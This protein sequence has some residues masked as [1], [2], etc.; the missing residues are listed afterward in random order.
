MT[1]FT[2]RA[3][4]ADCSTGLL[5][6]PTADM[7]DD[8]TFMITNNF[9]N[10][11][12]LPSSGWSYNSFQYGI[13][14]S[15]WGRME[16][17]YVCTLFNDYW[18]G[19]QTRKGVWMINQDRHF[20]G[21]IRL[22]KEGEFGLKWIPSLVVGASDPFTGG[23]LDYLTPGKVSGTGNGFFNRYFAVM[24]KHFQTH[25]GDLGVHAGYQYN[26]RKDYPINGPC[27]GINWSPVWLL[28]HG[29]LDGVN[30]IAEY[31]SRT[32]N[33]GFVASI[34]ENRFEAMFELQNF[35][36]INFG[37]RYKLRLKKINSL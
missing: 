15:F 14:V 19:R 30:L 33:M 8:G 24:T 37:L 20:T 10:K 35:N 18:K 25:W 1:V 21:R 29:I 22:L 32:V 16:V 36:S 2:C 9:L 27:F 6:M 31:D 7:Q 13:Y 26:Q 11:N 28:H 3:Q 12:T 34:W 4:F 17:G 5:Q 23:A